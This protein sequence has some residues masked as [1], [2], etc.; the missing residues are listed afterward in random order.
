MCEQ[1]TPDFIASVKLLPLTTSSDRGRSLGEC[2]S[3][4]KCG[5]DVFMS[6]ANARP[7]TFK[8]SPVLDLNCAVL[9]LEQGA[10]NRPMTTKPRP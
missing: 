6:Y 2:C 10:R 1:V 3:V 5:I 9:K 4:R 7:R 8:S